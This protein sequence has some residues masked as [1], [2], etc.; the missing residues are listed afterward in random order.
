MSDP[1]PS[2]PEVADVLVVGAGPVGLLTARLLGRAGHAVT[3]VERWPEPYPLPRAVHYDHEIGRILQSAGLAD[4]VRAVSQPVPDFYEWRN[5]DRE[6]LVRVDWSQPGPSGWP[7]ANFFS[8]P[9]LEAVLLRSVEAMPGVTVHRGNQLVALAERDGHVEATVTGT[10]GEQVE[11]RAR[12]VVGCDGANSFVRQWMD[13][14]VTDLGFWFD[15][16]IVDT[17]PQDDVEWS[18]MNWQLCD[19]ARP[20]TIVSGG[21]GRRRWEFMRLPH[22]QVADLDSEETAWRLL[23][24]W[25]RTPEN[26]VLERHA[27]YTFQARWA[28]QWR[29]R[30]VLVAGDAAHLMPPFA[31]QGMCSGMRDAANLSWKLDLVLRDLAPDALLD[32]YTTERRSHLR[33]A[34]EMSVALGRVICVL[35]EDEARQRDQ[36]M[37]AA[38]ADPRTVLPPMPPERLGPGAWDADQTP[39][40]L[41]GTLVPQFRVDVDG[42]VTLIDDVL[43]YGGTLIGYGVDPL[44]TLSDAERSE[45]AEVGVRGVALVE[46]GEWTATGAHTRLLV[47]A[48]TTP[49][50]WFTSAG[51]QAVVVR[52]D[53]YLF[54]AVADVDQVVTLARTYLDSLR[55]DS[56]REL[57]VP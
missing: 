32:T 34:I 49:G 30:R 41:H 2:P 53:F 47:G 13:T 15:W 16:L 24:T 8:Q 22:E 10:L 21:P 17:V 3:L 46:P 23:E 14:P 25:G 56:D 43:G 12:Y 27:V 52:P 31:G 29:Q 5:R 40:A 54:G 20:T 36:R 19:P 35:D 28:E 44:A 7:V 4:D 50:D 48:D 55:T 6:L 42:A 1:H 38:G 18:P 11:L 57:V 37:I 51:V 39:A 26:T 45:L 33:H 9:E